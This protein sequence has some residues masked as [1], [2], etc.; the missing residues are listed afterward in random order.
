MKNFSLKSAIYLVATLF[1]FT[2][3]FATPA[4]ASPIKTVELFVAGENDCS[5]YFNT[6]R[7]FSSC[8]I[9]ASD[10]PQMFISPVIAKFKGDLSGFEDVNKFYTSVVSASDWEFSD[11]VSDNV[12]GTWSY[13]PTDP[14]A[15]AVRFWSAKA[16]G[17]GN[18][19]GG[20][21]LFWNVTMDDYNSYCANDADTYD[22]MS[23]ALV[24]STGSWTTPAD[25]ELSHITFYNG[26][27][28]DGEEPPQEVPE[29]T[30]LVLM[31]L[32]LVSLLLGRRKKA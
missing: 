23:R 18:S 15:P 5:G 29:S 24:T 9:F 12:T 25:K 14:Q 4:K 7:G 2:L 32:G 17:K 19:G 22:C 26:R 13:N 8:Q 20:F 27:R 21:I 30:S 11:G 1:T 28:P 16:G 10:Q 3:L 6:G 31:G